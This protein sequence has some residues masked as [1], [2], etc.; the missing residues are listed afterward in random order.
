MVK[1]LQPN[2]DLLVL[3][4]DLRFQA[5]IPNGRN[6]PVKRRRDSIDAPSRCQPN[7]KAPASGGFFSNHHL[8]DDLGYDASADGTTAFTNGETQTFFHCDGLDQGNGHL[9]VITWH[10][11]FNAFRQFAVTGHVSGPEVELWTVAF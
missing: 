1:S 5:A 7:K 11:H 3:H 9:H 8:R 2:T 4:F 10:Y 6:T